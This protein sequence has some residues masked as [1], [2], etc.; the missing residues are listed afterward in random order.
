MAESRARVLQVRRPI[1]RRKGRGGFP[2]KRVTCANCGASHPGIYQGMACLI[3][4]LPI[5]AVRA[6]QD[7]A[8]VMDFEERKTEE[9]EEQNYKAEIAALQTERSELSATIA[10][11][12]RQND[13]SASDFALYVAVA[14]RGMAERDRYP[15]PES[16]TT[17]EAFY[18]VMAAAALDAIGPSALLGVTGRKSRRPEVTKEPRRRPEANSKRGRHRQLIRGSKRKRSR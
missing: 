14:A 18:I 3:C 10:D 11:L 6:H 17:P 2:R 13:V 5:G 7:D 12:R 16:V 15:M 9:A 4:G 1:S 8:R